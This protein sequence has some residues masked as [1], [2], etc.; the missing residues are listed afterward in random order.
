MFAMIDAYFGTSRAKIDALRSRYG[1]GYLVVIPSELRG[2]KLPRDW[3][4]MAPF[5]GVVAKL[6]H[7][8][9][10]PAAG[11]LPARCRTWHDTRVEVYSLACVARS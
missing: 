3:F 1:A 10:V 9:I 7:S 4:K 11:H 8:D 2:P 6:M 5:G